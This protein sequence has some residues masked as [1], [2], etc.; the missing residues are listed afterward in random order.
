L[1]LFDENYND[2]RKLAL[3]RWWNVN[4]RYC[5]AA[6]NLVLFTVCVHNKRTH[7]RVVM[8]ISTLYTS[9]IA[10]SVLVCSAD[11]RHQHIKT[12][13]VLRTLKIK[14]H[15]VFEVKFRSEINGFVERTRAVSIHKIEFRLSELFAISGSLE[16]VSLFSCVNVRHESK[17]SSWKGKQ[18]LA[19]EKWAENRNKLR[20][21]WTEFSTD[22]KRR[23]FYSVKKYRNFD[24]FYFQHRSNDATRILKTD[25]SSP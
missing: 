16:S 13:S 20:H 12:G 1:E 24:V 2:A 9:A 6:H 17:S 4:K 7:A 8:Q 23:F 22:W 3:R 14:N 5:I 19:R 15:C 25:S 11:K 21:H 10:I 18:T